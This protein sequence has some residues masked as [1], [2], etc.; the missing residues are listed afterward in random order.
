MLKS[1][2]PH[3]T[4]PPRPPRP[5][6][7][8]NDHAI[9]TPDSA[10]ADQERWSRVKK[11]LR[12]EVG[13]DIFSSWFAR[14]DIVTSDG[15]SVRLSVPTLFLKSWVQAHYIDRVLACWQAERAEVR[16]IE[17]IV[18]SSV[19]RSLAPKAKSELADERRAP[20]E[21]GSM[22]QRALQFGDIG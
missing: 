4:I 11:R 13:E 7:P 21:P 16:R 17:L 20:P 22:R 1:P 14:M 3:G 8:T 19:L 2:E 6:D 5:A 10:G 18:R 15:E 12:T 9:A